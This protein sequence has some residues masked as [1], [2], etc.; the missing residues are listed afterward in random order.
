MNWIVFFRVA[1]SALHSALAPALYIASVPPVNL[2]TESFGR[3]VPKLYQPLR[4]SAVTALGSTVVPPTE[5]LSSV[6]ASNTSTDAKRN[7]LLFIK[8]SDLCISGCD[9]F[10]KREKLHV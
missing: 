5:E 6:Q 1:P 4:T 7:I 8:R 3:P 10:C 2:L 9:L